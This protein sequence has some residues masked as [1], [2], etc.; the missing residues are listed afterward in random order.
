MHVE[1][2]TL[3][4]F[5]FYLSLRSVFELSNLGSFEEFPCLVSYTDISKIFQRYLR[6]SLF[7]NFKWLLEIYIGYKPDCDGNR[8]PLAC[9][10]ISGCNT[11]EHSTRAIFWTGLLNIN[12]QDKYWNESG[13][14]NGYSE[15]NLTFLKDV[16][17][18]NYCI[19]RRKQR[20]LAYAP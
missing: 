15:M 2:Y 18:H 14:E 1:R 9:T 10:K 20:K 5:G 13:N 17:L 19:S 3:H 6:W 7:Y 16:F 12:D 4:A 8:E 11:Y